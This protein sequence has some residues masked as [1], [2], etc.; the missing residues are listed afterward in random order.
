[1]WYAR[2]QTGAVKPRRAAI[3]SRLSEAGGAHPRPLLPHIL[4]LPKQV[5][6]PR[7]T[8]RD[9]R[10]KRAGALGERGQ[11]GIGKCV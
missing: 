4:F 2:G 10:R 1:M 7:A 9:V 6:E 8:V 11:E 3:N 5:K